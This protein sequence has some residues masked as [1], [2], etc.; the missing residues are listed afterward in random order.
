MSDNESFAD[1]NESFIDTVEDPTDETFEPQGFS[2]NLSLL[3]SPFRRIL[4]P[5]TTTTAAAVDQTEQESEMSMNL[6]QLVPP[7]AD[8]NYREWKSG[9]V[10]YLRCMK[11]YVDPTIEVNSLNNADKQKIIDSWDHINLSCDKTNKNLIANTKTST[12]AFEVLEDQ[13]AGASL[14]NKM[15]LFHDVF[16]TSMEAQ[17]SMRDY[18]AAKRECISQL[19]GMD[20]DLSEAAQVTSV[21]HNLPEE[22]NTVVASVMS[23]KDKN[24]KFDAV[25][26][27]LIGEESRLKQKNILNVSSAAASRMPGKASP[28][29][30]YKCTYPPCLRDGH[31]EDRC[32]MKEAHQ[33]RRQPL[34]STVTKRR[35]PQ[36][37]SSKAHKAA[38]NETELSPLYESAEDDTAGRA[39]FSFAARHHDSQLFRREHANAGVVRKRKNI[40]NYPRHSDLRLLISGMENKPVSGDAEVI[41]TSFDSDFINL[42]ADEDED[43][44]SMEENK[45]IEMYGF[46]TTQSSVKTSSRGIWLIDSGASTHMCYERS[47]F[48][49][50]DF[51]T[52]G[53]V[54][55]ADGTCIDIRGYGDVNVTIQ[56]G[57]SS[58]NL[59]LKKVA[60]VPDLD[61]NLLSVSRMAEKGYSVIFKDKKCF[62]V[63]N[64]QLCEFGTLRHNCYQLNESVVRSANKCV[65]E[66]H[67]LLAHRNL[68][69]IRRQP[70]MKID[71]CRCNADCESCIRGKLPHLPFPKVSQKPEHCLDL[72]V[73]DLEGP[74]PLESF[75]RYKYF[76]T[77][78][79]ARSNFTVVKLLRDKSECKSAVIEFMEFLNTN[80]GHYARVLRSD[81]GGEYTDASLQQYLREKGVKIELTVAHSPEQNGIAER[82]NR[83][84]CDAIRTLI[85]DS[86]MPKFL[87][88]EALQNAVYT[89]NRIVHKGKSITPYEQFFSK[90]PDPV[91]VEFGRDVFV[92]TT[93]E[94][95]KKLDDRALKMKILRVDDNS[96][97]FRLWDGSKIRVERNIKFSSGNIRN[98][99][100]NPV[101]QPAPVQNPI[102]EPQLRRSPRLQ[103]LKDIQTADSVIKIPAGH[104]P[105]TFKQA[106][107]SEE[108]DLWMKSMEE[109]LNTIKQNGTWTLVD[110][111][112]DRRAVGSKWVFKIK[113]DQNNQPVKYKSRLVA[114]G[115]TQKFGV[116][117]DEVFAPVARS[118]TFRTLLSVASAKRMKLKQFDV[119]AAFLN[120]RL[121]EEV[122]LKQP[123]GFALGD[124]VY[125]LH[126]SLYGLKQAARVWNKTLDSEM[127]NIGFEQS[128]TDPCL[129]TYRSGSALCFTI[130]H[131]DDCLVAAT[132]T[133][134]IDMLMGQLARKFELKDLGRA[135]HFLGIDITSLPDGSFEISQHAYIDKLA[136]ELGLAEA[137]SSK[138]PLDP[139][140]Y[141]IEDKNLLSDNTE[142][143]TIIGKLLY[144]SVHTRPDIS[145]CVNILAQRVA[146]P[147][148]ADLTEAKRAVKYLSGTKSLRLRFSG[149]VS[150]NHSLIS[151][152]DANWAESRTDRKSNS[153]IVCLLN[154]A[155]VSWSSKKQGVVATSTTEAELYAL[156][157]AAKD[158]V[159]FHQLLKDFDVNIHFPI[160]LSSDN[161]SAIKML[162]NDKF[163]QRTKHIDVQFHFLK[164]LVSV[165][166]LSLNYVPTESN[167]ADLLTKPLAG[168]RIQMLRELI[169]FTCMK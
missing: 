19:A 141:K 69:E 94:G 159:W 6:R 135:Q 140:Y 31:T 90:R 114:Q 51:C 63:S 150:S 167:V 129:Y 2:F 11:L 125:R 117:F 49:N 162:T 52:T 32:F 101:N 78:V 128:R 57:G 166:K 7:L 149:G 43:F 56:S 50:I 53:V 97:G 136:S 161:Q 137:K 89:F 134:V 58:H 154:G 77:F 103:H 80:L 124:K 55:I 87:W 68:R 1:T 152:S 74:M 113:R 41:S 29:V 4:R 39:S 8:N 38:E 142:Y 85:F 14:I 147:R 160:A 120:G 165:G 33:R 108:K 62:F 13:Y 66:W 139:G 98:R 110:L 15:G 59:L 46:S 72:I 157:E 112:Q 168:T 127:K 107:A 144:L 64:G 54:R 35:Q 81:R 88:S 153:G 10:S 65:H 143:R 61:M 37:K 82:M 22:Y 27:L 73:S 20:E 138:Y 169:G 28:M 84:L 79:D 146:N 104:E 126:K 16:H 9:M 67:K 132:D 111:P 118:Q 23:W 102:I 30:R 45:I 100:S 164:D 26:K 119:A 92:A 42:H 25:A 76:I 40:L 34:S 83:T 148:V 106:V 5:R 18:L 115:F 123:P 116:D 155:P 93:R 109:E 71:K 75:G 86:N 121:D 158:L 3:A 60:F 17:Q 47:R 151:F 36:F 105:K 12:E 48:E 130:L 24:L 21:L 156:A 145:A 131:V 70:D 95:R 122:Y 96:K 133:E 91:F 44:L 163:S 99:P